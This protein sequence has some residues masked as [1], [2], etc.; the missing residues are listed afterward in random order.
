M[1]GRCP[2]SRSHEYPSEPQ[3]GWIPYQGRRIH[4]A[5]SPARAGYVARVSPDLRCGHTGHGDAG[6]ASR[7]NH[8]LPQGLQCLLQA[9]L[10]RG[11]R[12][13]G[14]SPARCYQGVAESGIA[15]ASKAALRPS[16]NKLVDAG[17]YDDVMAL[18]CK[19]EAR[20]QLGADYYELGSNARSLKTMPVP[21]TRNA[22]G[23]PRIPG[24]IARE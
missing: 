16:A 21:F 18:Q 15:G 23:V 17:M 19:D 20:Q 1:A 3:C 22:P 9:P 11:H 12:G 2:A 10:C 4:P 5:R 14:V 6:T 7:R 24:D 8:Q 13:R